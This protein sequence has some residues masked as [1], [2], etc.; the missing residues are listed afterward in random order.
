LIF[1]D[2]AA[3]RE[4]EKMA[5][6]HCLEDGLSPIARLF[7]HPRRPVFK[8]SSFRKWQILG[9]LAIFIWKNKAMAN[10]LP[11]K[12]RIKEGDTLLPINAPANFRTTLGDLPGRVTFVGRHKPASQVH[13]FVRDRAQMEGE[14]K[15]VL[16]LVKEGVLLW[17]YYPKGSSSQQTDLTRDK[18]WEKLME[19]GKGLA[20]LTLISFD[21]TWSMFGC[22]LKTKADEKKLA[23]KPER[24]IFQWIDPKAK[25]VRL[26]EDVAAALKK[27]KKEGAKFDALA[28]SHKKEYLEWIITAKRPET[29]EERIKGT[30]ERL[31]KDWKNPRNM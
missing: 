28:F 12:L 21:E 24:E 17:I 3:Q 30:V 26:P 5:E 1:N 9:R 16:P 15:E 2:Y 22:R 4:C 11:K 20:W 13:W 7:C 23:N 14:M 6:I 10:P 25:T 31:G 27:N 19:K 29:R 8:R 18:G